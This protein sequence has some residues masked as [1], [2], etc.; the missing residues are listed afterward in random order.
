MLGNMGGRNDM[1]LA[2]QKVLV[3]PTRHPSQAESEERDLRLN[4]SVLYTS[5]EPTVAALKEAGV[6]ASSLSAR[7]TLLVP[8]VVP[9]ILP[10]ESPSVL[11]EFNENRFRGIASQSPV[12]TN[13]QVYLCRDKVRT[14]ASVL[15]PGSIVVMGGRKRRWWPTG[16]ERLA[17]ELRRAGHEVIF[18]QT[19]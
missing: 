1:S 18:K 14:L 13:V 10:L 16:D 15:N 3:S 6:L 7:L 12:E 5:L 2:V 11:V 8:R 4:I 19:E 17:R 9:Y